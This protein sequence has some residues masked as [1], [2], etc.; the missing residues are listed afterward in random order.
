MEAATSIVHYFVAC[1]IFKNKAFPVYRPAL[2]GVLSSR[3]PVLGKAAKLF[4][5]L[6]GKM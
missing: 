1:F 4:L 3:A 6:G 5:F 2:G